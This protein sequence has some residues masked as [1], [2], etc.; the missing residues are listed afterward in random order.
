MKPRLRKTS[1][2]WSCSTGPLVVGWG[3]TPQQAYEMWQGRTMPLPPEP[4]APLLPLFPAPE[5]RPWPWPWLDN[6][7]GA[8]LPPMP[9]LWSRH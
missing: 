1:G 4:W 7:T 9:T 3:L 8:P 2:L 5:P 6:G